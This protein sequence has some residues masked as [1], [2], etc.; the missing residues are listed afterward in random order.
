ML[1]EY[2]TLNSIQERL[3]YL[4]DEKIFKQKER[5]DCITRRTNLIYWGYGYDS[6]YNLALVWIDTELC[7]RGKTIIF[8]LSTYVNFNSA[9]RT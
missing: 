8:P 2:T 7:E 1:H 6:V 9:S 3:G 4:N 5:C